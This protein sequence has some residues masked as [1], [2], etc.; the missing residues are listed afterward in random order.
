MDPRVVD[1]MMP[2]F[3]DHYGNAGSVSHCYGWDA[4]DAV[5]QAAQRIA[6]AIG[7]RPKEIVFTSGATE[8]NNLAI[9]GTADCRRR[10]GNHIVSVVTEHKAVL[11]PL[12]RLAR[13]GFDVTLLDV[14]PQSSAQPGTITVEQVAGA[15]RDDTALVSVMLANNEIGVIQPVAEIGQLCKQ[16]GILLHCDAAQALGKIPVDVEHLQVDLLSFSGHKFHGPRGIGGLFVRR[17]N[18]SVKLEPQIVGG[19]QQLGLRSGT[20]NVPGIVGLACAL[21]LCC[22]EMPSETARLMKLKLRLYDQLRHSVR[23]MA[24]NGPPLDNPELRLPGNLNIRFDYVDG[25]ALMMSVGTVAMSSGSA[26]TSAN[27]E[28]SYVLR[29]LGL[30]DDQVRSS[31][32]FGLGRFNTE[33]DIDFAVKELAAAVARLRKLSSMARP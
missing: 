33:E 13:N 8:S 10:R 9:Q 32:R 24:L 23:D 11:D 25:E 29:A 15:I 4:A 22:D 31:L 27:P 1:A 20:L 12:A 19:G 6:D 21:D 7:A 14:S 2:Y 28:P 5:N 26:C 17:R 3:L 16:H 18:P 30:G